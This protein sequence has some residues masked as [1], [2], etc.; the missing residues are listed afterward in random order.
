MLRTFLVICVIPAL[1]TAFIPST[2]FGVP[3]VPLRIVRCLA[4]NVDCTDCEQPESSPNNEK[5]QQ[6]QQQHHVSIEYCT[7][8][9]WMMRAAWM[10]QELLTTFTDEL[11]S[12]TLIPNRAKPGGVFTVRRNTNHVVWD[13]TTDGGFPESKQLKQRI[14]DFIA[15]DRNLGHSDSSSSTTTPS[16]VVSSSSSSPPDVC[17][18]CP[19]PI[20]SSSDATTAETPRPQLQQQPNVAI[21]YCTGCRWLLRASWLAQELLT[22][23]QDDLN[24][25]TL[26]PSRPPLAQ[27]GTFRIELNGELLWDRATQERFPEPKEI[28]QLTRDRLCPTRKLGHADRQPVESDEMLMDDDEA[29]EM[30]QFFGVL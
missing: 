2:S 22:T 19:D 1:A 25:V 15:P 9:R 5:Q 12:M 16:L 26:I 7:G 8:C 27:G 6:Q 4:S 30:R 13:R 23:F 29:E 14:R 11:D 21:T 10:A 18:D 17:P 24:S 3:V 28:K 20:P